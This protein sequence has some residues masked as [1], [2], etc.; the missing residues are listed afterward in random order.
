M[1]I[2]KTP[3]RLSHADYLALP[4]GRYDLIEGFLVMTPA[5][6]RRHQMLVFRLAKALDAHVA[7]AACG[8]VYLAPL[9]VT[10]RIDD[11]AIVVQPDV[12]Y[13]ARDGRA[14]LT[15]MGVA[16]PPDL[17]IEVLSPSN[18]ALDLVKK[19]ALYEAHGVRE[20][21][22]VMPEGDQV[23]V[24]RR[25]EAGF[26][27]PVLLEAPDDLETPLLPGFKLALGALFAPEA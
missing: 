3:A 11:P 27:R 6:S 16:G 15:D 14:A 22:I 23:Q 26:G 12:L 4:E 10:L 25:G 5:P 19:R 9:D 17:V 2:E 13:V 20:Y 8:H 18:L 7:A 1:A 24:L 21:W